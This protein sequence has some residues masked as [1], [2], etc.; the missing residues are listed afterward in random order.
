MHKQPT[1][2][3]PLL[4]SSSPQLKHKKGLLLFFFH[5]YNKIQLLFFSLPG[6]LPYLN[7]C[8]IQFCSCQVFVYK[9]I[10]IHNYFQGRFYSY[11]SRH[12]PPECADP[13]TERQLSSCIWGVFQASSLQPTALKGLQKAL[14]LVSAADLPRS[15]PFLPH[16][17]E[18]PMLPPLSLV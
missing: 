3:V 4:S 7:Q 9:A 16:C 1:S 14:L 15:F 12:L 17:Q 8:L 11:D 6:F 10:V 2:L 18:P 13:E 5:S